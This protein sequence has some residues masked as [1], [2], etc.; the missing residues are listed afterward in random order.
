MTYLEFKKLG[1]FGYAEDYDV[2][3]NGI[4]QLI[5]KIHA[6]TSTG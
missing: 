3:K 1:R 6:P 4:A 5:E 2:F